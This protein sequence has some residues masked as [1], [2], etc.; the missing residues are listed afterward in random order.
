MAEGMTP[1]QIVV[2]SLQGAAA[3]FSILSAL[4][5]PKVD[6]PRIE[7]DPADLEKMNVAIAANTEISNQAREFISSAIANYQDGKLM[8]SYQA[9]LDEWWS[10]SVTQLEQVLAS[11]GLTDSSIAQNAR[12]ELMDSYLINHG[13]LMQK[14]LNDALSTSGLTQAD[15]ASITQKASIQL[16]KSIAQANL[17]MR[18]YEAAAALGQSRGAA[19]GALSSALGRLESGIKPKTTA[20]AT[21]TTKPTTSVGTATTSIGTAAGPW[22]DDIDFAVGPISRYDIPHYVP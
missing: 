15:I 20:T 8:P 10:K 19:L 18:S 12:K 13:N 4:N 11:R 3:A 16:N 1:L 17:T 2:A 6:I 21:A 14:Q 7:I 22:F 5:P 9:Q